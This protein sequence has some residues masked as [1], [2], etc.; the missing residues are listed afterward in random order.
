M[1]GSAAALRPFEAPREHSRGVRSR[2]RVA[3]ALGGIALLTAASAP[4]WLPV[5]EPRGF[6]EELRL[7]YVRFACSREPHELRFDVA[8][9]AI[10]N[11]SFAVWVDSRYLDASV[12]EDVRP[13]PIGRSSEPGRL[14]FEFASVPGQDASV[15]FRLLPRAPGTRTARAGVAGGRELE[16]TQHLRP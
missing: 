8:G 16:F 7:E 2:T 15:V 6:A 9:R 14:V 11:P 10:A 5:R 1:S 12:L 3:I 4:A 13:A